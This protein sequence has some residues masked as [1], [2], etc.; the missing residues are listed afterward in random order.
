[1]YD[2]SAEREL[3]KLTNAERD[4]SDLPPLRTDEAW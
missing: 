3:L 1:V 2:V 4:R